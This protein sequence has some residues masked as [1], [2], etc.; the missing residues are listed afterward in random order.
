MYVRI[1]KI[2]SV[3]KTLIDE[4][5]VSQI[6]Q[7][8]NCKYDNYKKYAKIPRKDLNNGRKT[9]K[10]NYIIMGTRIPNASKTNVNVAVR[11]M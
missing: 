2:R 10:D 5:F 6:L 3:T 1:M 8:N 11:K 7:K 9:N 4:Q